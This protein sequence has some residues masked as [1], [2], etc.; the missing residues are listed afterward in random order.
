[1]KQNHAEMLPAA[2]LN[3]LSNSGAKQL[4]KKLP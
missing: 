4:N 3:N 2:I 1:M